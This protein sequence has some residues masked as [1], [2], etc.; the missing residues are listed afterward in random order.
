MAC[1]TAGTGKTGTACTLET[2]CA[3]GLTCSEDLCR[4]YCTSAE[5]GSNCTGTS[6]GAPL[7]VC[8]QFDS[9]SDVPIP[10]DSFCL[11]K[12]SL[13]PNSCPAGQGCIPFETIGGVYY[14]DCHVAGTVAPS[15]SCTSDSDCIAGSG[16]FGTTTG[17]CAQYCRTT[18][19]C[20]AGTCNTSS[21]ATVNGVVYGIC[22]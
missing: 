13:W 19:D 3:A 12:C 21:T 10:Q 17:V 15:G 16:C 7:G 22:E 6:G 14:S 20:G 9:T 11:F 8:L 2:D 4:P 1:I 5:V 18:T